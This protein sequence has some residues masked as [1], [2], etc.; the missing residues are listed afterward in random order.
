MKSNKKVLYSLIALALLLSIV[1]ISVGF[2]S[3][4]TTLNMNGVANVTPAS[5]KIKFQN[6]SNASITGYAEVLSNPTIQSDTHIGDYS[7]KLTRPGDKV[8]YTFEVANL[9]TIDSEISSYSF[10]APIVTGTGENAL[11]DSEIVKNNLVYTLTYLDGTNVQIG[12]VLNKNEVTK[13]K[14]TIAYRE[15]ATDLPVNPVSITGM[16]ITFVYGQK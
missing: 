6:L 13:L 5:W 1:G 8:E 15:T 7:I 4:S 10:L 3:M 11:A 16:D 2:A 14:L 12:D 9:G